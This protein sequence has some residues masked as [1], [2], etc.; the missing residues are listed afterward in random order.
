MHDNDQTSASRA[1]LCG[2]DRGGEASPAPRSGTITFAVP[3]MLLTSSVI[4]AVAWL[5][6]LKFK[7]LPFYWA[8]PAAWLIVLP[9]YV[10]NVGAIRLGYGTYTGGNMATFNLCTGVLCVAL[11]SW[12]VLDEALTTQKILGFV[13]M[14]VA[15]VLVAA[16]PEA[17]QAS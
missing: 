8:I 5:G 7:E 12:L 17:R 3:L 15:M 14:A 2:A 13:L 16:K 9:E 10:L 4:M 6:H 11:V 1:E